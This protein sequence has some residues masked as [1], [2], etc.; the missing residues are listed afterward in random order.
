MR[1]LVTNDDGYAYKGIETL[2]EI[3]RPLGEI[4]V[5]CPKYHQSGTS[6]AVSMGFKP[7]AVKQFRT[8][9][10]PWYYIDATP[11]SCVKYALDEIYTDGAP[12]LVVSG[13]NHGMNVGSAALYSGTL[14]ACRE[15]ALAGVPAVGISLDSFNPDADFSTLARMFPK[16]LLR[17]LE[18][19]SGRFG[20]YYNVNFPNLPEKQ[21]KGIRFGKQGV[22]H[23]V[24]EF[25]PYDHRAFSDYVIL[26]EAVGRIRIPEIEP[27]EK[28]YMMAGD[29]VSDPRNTPDCDN[30]LLEEGYIAISPLTIDST[31]YEEL[32]MLKK[33]F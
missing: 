6:M 4:T 10:E 26:P 22:Q 31:D 25:R 12:D 32:E 11:S 23:W 16:I 18:V 30:V 1:I 21:I 15:A 5:V 20:T 28:V 24:K 13:I 8:K 2:V 33:A 27:D 29:M 19:S 9:P 14:G 3:L 17:L 7:I